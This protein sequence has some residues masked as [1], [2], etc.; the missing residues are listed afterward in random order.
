[1]LFSVLM[2]RFFIRK[3][4]VLSWAAV[5]YRGLSTSYVVLKYNQINSTRKQTFKDLCVKQTCV[6]IFLYS[7][8]ILLVYLFI[9]GWQIK[10][11]KYETKEK[12][13]QEINIL[14]PKELF[15]Q[16]KMMTLLQQQNYHNQQRH[17]YQQ[18]LKMILVT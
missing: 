10:R 2:M 18:K 17:R 6:V 1:M 11:M 8:Y 9:F 14:V 7:G 12:K 16:K 4:G 5:E 3:K 15:F 13:M